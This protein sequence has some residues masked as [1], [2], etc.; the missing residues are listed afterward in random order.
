MSSLYK[1]RFEVVFLVTH[2]KGPKMSVQQVAKYTKTSVSYVKKW[3]KRYNDCG[4][5]DD[6][7]GRGL[8]KVTSEKDDKVILKLFE[9]NPTMN[10]CQAKK[11]YG[12]KVLEYL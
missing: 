3:I 5:V 8:D 9:K 7:L 4:N 2:P 6:L 12:R 1:K 11:N 10:L